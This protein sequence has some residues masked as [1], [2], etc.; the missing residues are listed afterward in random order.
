MS[1]SHKTSAIARPSSAVARI[2]RSRR[3]R[4]QRRERIA[5]DDLTRGVHSEHRLVTS[6]S[7]RWVLGLLGVAVVGALLAA[8][9]VLP[10]QAWMRQQ[11]E[12]ELK[13]QELN[14]LTEANEDLSAEVQHLE[15]V[16]GARE[17]A[18]DELGVIDRGEERISILPSA[19]GALPL[20]TG[21]PYD[22][23]SQIVAVRMAPP[24]TVPPP[25]AAPATV[26]ASVAPVEQ[27][28]VA[29]SPV[30]AALVTAESVTAP[31]EQAPVPAAPPATTVP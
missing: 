25:T 23:V 21:W 20:P 16:E 12:I 1:G 2:G 4:G 7:N 14:V 31:V 5:L 8:L 17:A 11:D 24:V 28:P 29:E 15:T 26:A 19:G 6:R 13:Q 3:P 27:A 9:F 22:A 10:V 30:T 18:R